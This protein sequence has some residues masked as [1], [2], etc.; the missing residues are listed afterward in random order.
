[1]EKNPADV[2][3][4]IFSKYIGMHENG[5]SNRAPWLDA[6]QMK[7]GMKGQPWCAIILFYEIIPKAELVLGRQSV[8]QASAHV[9]TAAKLNKTWLKKDPEAGDVFFLG[10]KGASTGHMGYVKKVSLDGKWYETI[11]GNTSAADGSNRD[12]GEVAEHKRPRGDHQGFE[13]L[14]F[15]TPFPTYKI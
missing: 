9:R 2:L 1:M 5:G 15:A 13:E 11:E 14:G 6:I 4:E 3:T 8:L 10:K 7:A 12:G